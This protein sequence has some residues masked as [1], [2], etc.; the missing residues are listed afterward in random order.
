M[1]ESTYDL[2]VNADG[3][4]L[5]AIRDMEGEPESPRC[6]VYGNGEAVLFKNREDALTLSGLSEEAE[7]CLRKVDSVLIV[8][9]GDNEALREYVAEVKHLDATA[10]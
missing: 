2:L 9:V 10:R 5:I 8:E 3:E 6:V 7:A 1:E 4:V